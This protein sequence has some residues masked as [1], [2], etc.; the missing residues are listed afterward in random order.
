MSNGITEKYPQANTISLEKV[1]SSGA[2]NTWDDLRVSANMIDAGNSNK[3]IWKLFRTDGTAAPANFA[4]ELD[5]STQYMDMP[6]YADLDTQNLTIEMWVK[7]TNSSYELTYRNGV[8]DTYVSNNRVYAAIWGQSSLRSNDSLTQ[9]AVNH[10][11][12]TFLSNGSSTTIS[13]YIN[14][15]LSSS[16]VF[17]AVLPATGVDGYVFGKWTSGW[18]LNGAMDFIRLYNVA[19]TDV[20]VT[21]AY[22]NGLGMTS[23]TYPTG[24]TEATD[25]LANFPLDEGSGTTS[26]NSC[27]LGTGYDVTLYNSPTWVS[28]LAGAAEAIGGVILPAFEKGSVIQSAYFTAQLPHSYAYETEMHPHIHWSTVEDTGGG[29]VCWKLEYTKSKVFEEF[30]TTQTVSGSV[31]A[32]ST[33]VVTDPFKHRYTNLD[34]I[35]MTGINGISSMFVCRL[36]RD[37]TD[38]SDT[39]NGD[40]YLLEFD[41]HFQK[42]TI[43]SKDEFTK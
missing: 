20:Q 7:P 42:D 32:H 19:L 17:S 11:V 9:N 22:N 35:D 31:Q 43:G 27:T 40:A 3:P 25:V 37:V 41:F 30:P 26:V 21:E 1:K 10:I 38:P 4:V 34:S 2:T 24:I 23:T 16:S 33:A 39:F 14:G 15:A 6:Y 36:Y 13:I 28:G 18:Y 8:V 12:V 29:E 5:G